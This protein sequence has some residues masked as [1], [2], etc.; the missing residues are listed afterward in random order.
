MVRIIQHSL[1]TWLITKVLAIIIKKQKNKKKFKAQL[2]FAELQFFAE[3]DSA[4]KKIRKSKEM[5]EGSIE[6]MRRGNKRKRE[7]Q[8]DPNTTVTQV[9]D[10]SENI[11]EQ[12]RI[13]QTSSLSDNNNL[14]LDDQNPN[15]IR[16]SS[17]EKSN[18][19]QIDT[20]S[21]PKHQD[22][23]NSFSTP[24][25]SSNS[26]LLNSSRFSSSASEV[27]IAYKCKPIW[28]A[29]KKHFST[30]KKVMGLF[31]TEKEALLYCAHK[32]KVEHD[33]E[34]FNLS[35][36]KQKD[37]DDLHSILDAYT[38]SKESEGLEPD[39][40]SYFVVEEHTIMNCEK[41]LSHYA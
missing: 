26:Y 34:K 15:K 36:M 32:I 31:E 5:S 22:N 20:F 25:C 6:G 33:G 12:G 2:N 21:T 37:E 29:R 1:K 8:E 10:I 19:N 24:T 16:K 7:E 3:T 14:Q 35:E 4:A 11:N 23:D 38:E 40:F 41:L 39:E 17:S 27:Y 9:I 28:N 18:S 13:I 30:R